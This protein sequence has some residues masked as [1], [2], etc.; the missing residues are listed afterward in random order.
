MD[1]RVQPPKMGAFSG[2]LGRKGKRTDAQPRFFPLKPPSS[3][4]CGIVRPVLETADF[5]LHIK[6]TSRVRWQEVARMAQDTP[7]AQHVATGRSWC[8]SDELYGLAYDPDPRRI[9]AATFT[10]EQ[11]RELLKADKIRP[12]EGAPRA[13]V[14]AFTIVQQEKRRLRVI[15]EPCI[16]PTCCKEKMYEV[17]YPSRLERRA[18]ARGAAYSVEI[19]FAAF[20]DQFDLDKRVQP[21]FVLRTKE[22][23]DGRNL[24][25][26]TRMPMGAT[27]APSVAQTVTSVLVYPLLSISG[28]RV[29]TMIDNV[30][31]VADNK[32]S[33]IRALRLFLERAAAAD[34]TLNDVETLQGTDDELAARFAV[35]DAPRVF[36]GEKYVRD[37]VSN[38]DRL[39]EKLRRAAEERTR[40]RA[41]DDPPYTKRH[42]ASLIGLMLFMAHTLNVPLSRHHTLLRAYANLINASTSWDEP[43]PAI[44]AA[45]QSE[46]D[47]L[48]QWLLRNEPVD[49]P[50]L[51]PPSVSVKD[52]DAAIEVDASCTAWGAKVLFPATGEVFSLQQRWTSPV[53]H[54][55]WAEPRAALEAV[56][57][58]R[59]RLGGSAKIALI[60]DHA[61]MATGQRRWHANHGGFSGSYH[62]NAFYDELYAHGEGEVFYVEGERN[63]ADQ[64]SRDAS[65]PYQLR[66]TA[67]PVTFKELASVKHPYATIPRAAFQV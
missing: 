31:I 54:S 17:H 47:G 56:R 18:R 21:W 4:D 29:D 9:P 28:V 36:L 33:F 42:F 34:I 53:N 22:P 19:D 60:T 55:A 45:A 61:A 5:P 32:R 65:A 67:S 23:V 52:Y 41:L 49:L 16:N 10:P 20:F 13:F 37:T 12:L 15:A 57:W 48:L 63:E 51:C 58:A 14:N 3:E 39:V 46:L 7:L 44:S 11:V 59:R 40:V 2:F 6:A 27:F 50:V 1:A 66:A 26:L 38:A 25:A 43:C 35:G 64:L 8:G 24:F 62:L 30:R